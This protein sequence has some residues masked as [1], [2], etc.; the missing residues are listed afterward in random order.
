MKNI[1]LLFKMNIPLDLLT[2]EILPRLRTNE[3]IKIMLN[4][5]NLKQ[6]GT[7]E[8]TNRG[9]NQDTK[10]ILTS[11][12]EFGLIDIAPYSTVMRQDRFYF[13]PED[14]PYGNPIYDATNDKLI[15]LLQKIKRD[16]IKSPSRRHQLDRAWFQLRVPMVNKT[17]KGLT[18]NL[19]RVNILYMEILI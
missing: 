10:T 19:N 8:L 18:V 6:L 7:N 3:I 11:V 1:L 13:E 5:P 12:A 15:S 14:N 4:T 16:E 2:H 9:Y 17:Q